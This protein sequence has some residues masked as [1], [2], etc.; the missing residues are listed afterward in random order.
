MVAYGHHPRLLSSQTSRSQI[1]TGPRLLSSQIVHW[2]CNV[3]AA[4]LLLRSSGRLRGA[5]P[6]PDPPEAREASVGGSA[7]EMNRYRVRQHG[8]LPVN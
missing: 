4:V 1:P 7:N 2:F 5:K 3:R 8:H 6:P